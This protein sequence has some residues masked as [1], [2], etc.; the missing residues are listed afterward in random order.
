[1][2]LRSPEPGVCFGLISSVDFGPEA[3]AATFPLGELLWLGPGAGD[4]SVDG[5]FTPSVDFAPEAR[6]TTFPKAAV[7]DWG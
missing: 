7:A 4:N 6:A 2:G 1:M 3:R 5:G